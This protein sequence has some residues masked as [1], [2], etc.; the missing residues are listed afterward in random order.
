MEVVIVVGLA[1]LA[2]A[3]FLLRGGSAESRAPAAAPEVMGP[4]VD[5]LT[6]RLRAHLPGWDVEPDRE[7]EGQLV[8]SDSA[9][10]RRM[11]LELGSL[12]ARWGELREKSP[13]AADEVLASFV[14]RVSTVAS[15]PAEEADAGSVLQMLALHL[16]R[17]EELPEGLLV[18]RAGE[19]QA[20]L[21]MR[22]P[23]GA[24][25]LAEA[26]LEALGTTVDQ[27]FAYARENLQRD[28]SEGLALDPVAGPRDRPSAVE[29]AR[30][31]PLASSYAAVPDLG[32]WLEKTLRT[33]EP[34]L[35]PARDGRLF[36]CADPETA[37]ALF[38][39]LAPEER[40]TRQPIAAGSLRA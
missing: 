18:R 26:D 7:E 34:W 6:A 29:V 31:D 36:A 30:G 8:V 19:L 23:Q 17:P 24:E 14:E 21:V 5:E 37:R 10:G 12:A 40:L 2:G 20:V 35:V 25:P 9:T 3:W 13:A 38:E 4:L 32:G 22:H 27:A 15:A 39:E 33:R 28:A 16:V 1:L 11:K